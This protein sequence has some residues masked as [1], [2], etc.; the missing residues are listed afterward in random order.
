EVDRE[1]LEQANVAVLERRD[2]AVRVDLQVLRRARLADEADAH[3]LVGHAE[4]LEHPERPHRARARNPV[5]LDH[6][7]L[8][9]GS[10][11]A[12]AGAEPWERGSRACT[13]RSRATARRSSPER[14]E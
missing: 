12:S 7:V 8:P 9:S 4:L 6:R 5:E 11:R 13:S 10:R 1:R 2:V 3:V 14:A